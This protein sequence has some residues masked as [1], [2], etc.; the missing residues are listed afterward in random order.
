[1]REVP[2]KKIVSALALVPCLLFPLLTVP[3]KIPYPNKK[4]AFLPAALRTSARK[5]SLQILFLIKEYWSCW[6]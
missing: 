5:P 4:D 1:M 3:M 6:H 2:M